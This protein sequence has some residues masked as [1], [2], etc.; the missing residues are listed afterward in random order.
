MTTNH[1]DD[2]ISQLSDLLN[3]LFIH[4]LINDEFRDKIADLI[5]IVGKIA[6]QSLPEPRDFVRC[7]ST[8][9]QSDDKTV[10]LYGWVTG[11]I[12]RGIDPIA[13]IMGMDHKIRHYH[14]QEI[15]PTTIEQWM[16][17]E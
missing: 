2:R 14:A 16:D 9:P 3:G 11:D 4:P 7:P 8:G 5:P 1:I 10:W 6:G 15:Q 17:D 13:T 12:S